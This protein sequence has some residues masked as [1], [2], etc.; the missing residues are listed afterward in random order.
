MSASLAFGS[1]IEELIGDEV[2]KFPR[3]SMRETSTIQDAIR[4]NR[5][6]A[7]RAAA[8]EQGERMSAN[9]RAG[10]VMQASVLPVT[11]TDIWNYLG[12]RPGIESAL[13]AS[14]VKGGKQDSEA[15][16]IIDNID[17]FNATSLARMVVGAITFTPSDKVGKPEERDWATERVLIR[18]LCP[19]LG[20]PEELTRPQYE[21]A[22]EIAK[23]RKKA[24][25][26]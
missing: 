17:L 8:N 6:Q 10:F 20:A 3:L 14:L 5:V 18:E 16:S 9:D 7:A 24:K 13:K 26:G 21:Q 1:P 15:V 11:D 19:N 22:L 23:A 25:Q 2:V 12:T 4:A